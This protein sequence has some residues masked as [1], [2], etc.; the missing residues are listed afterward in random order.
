MG[1]VKASSA[2]QSLKMSF[3]SIKLALLVGICG[4]VPFKKDGSEIVLGDV[5]IS[6]TIVELDYGRQYHG[7]FERKDSL[8]DVHGRPNEEILGLLQRWK[9]PAILETLRHGS[10]GHLRYLLQRLNIDYP[11]ASQDMLFQSDYIH[12]HRGHCIG[13]SDSPGTV[14]KSALT[15]SCS[16]TLCDERQLVARYRLEAAKSSSKIPD[17]SIHIGSIGTGNAVIKSAR[18]RDQHTQSEGIIAFEMEGVGVWDKFNCLVIKGVCDYAD[19]HKSKVWQD[20]AAAAAAAV[21]KEVLKQYVMPQKLP[22][23]TIPNDSV[24]ELFSPSRQDSFRD[25]HSFHMLTPRYSF[26]SAIND[27]EEHSV[28]DPYNR[29]AQ[30]R[31]LASLQFPQ[32]QGR[33][34]KIEAA[35]EQTY[36]WVLRSQDK[37]V[38]TWDDLVT[39]LSSST[40]TRWIYWISGKP[41]SGKSTLMKFLGERLDVQEH[42]L[43]WAQGCSVIRASYFSWSPGNVLQKS[44]EGLLRSL[45]LQIL[46]QK[47]GLMSE[48]I[49]DMRW[50]A[51]QM[52]STTLAD[53]NNLEL[54]SS[55]QRCIFS[56]QNVFIRV[57]FFV[58]GLDEF[59]G[60]DEIRQE[61][62]AIFKRL[63]CTGNVKIFL[64][65]RPWNIFQDSFSDIPKIRLEDLTRDDIDLYV[66]ANFLNNPRFQYLLRCDQKAAEALIF[67][68]T[69]KAEGVF[70]WVRLVVRDLLKAMRDGDGIRTLYRKLEEIPADL[71]DYFKHLFSS[72][73]PQHMREASIILQTA[74]HEEHDFV[75]LHPLRLLD[76][77]FTDESSPDFALA[78]S[79]KH[80]KIS[81]NDREAL[82]FRLDSTIR[83]LNSRCMGLLECTYNPDSFFDLFDEESTEEFQDTSLYQG[84]KFEPSIYSHV[85][86]SPTLLRPFML[87]VDF[88][89]RCCRDFLLFPHIQSLLHQYTGGR[90]DARM[91]IINARISQFLALQNIECGRSISLGIASYLVSALSVPEWKEAAV[92]IRAARILQ[93]AI[94]AFSCYDVASSPGWYIDFVLASWQEEKSNFLTLAIDF[95]MRAYCMAYLTEDQVQ[96]KKGRPILD[97][98][99]RPRF[100]TEQFLNIGSQV[101]NIDLLHRVLTFGADPNGLYQGVSVWALFLS[102]V[103]E[104]LQRGFHTSAT[105]KEAYLMA[106][107][108]MI[109]RGAAL[110]LP[111][112]W[113]L[114]EGRCRL[115]RYGLFE[116]GY[117]KK[118]RWPKDIPTIEQ[119]VTGLSQPS[120][121]VTDLLATFQVHFGPE[122]NG[123]IELAKADGYQHLLS[124]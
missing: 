97:Y 5:I 109:N 96:A 94:E 60:T 50:S 20:Y 72:I 65:S 119:A 37:N 90:Y 30:Q 76:L 75:A 4:A 67:A 25:V 19:S 38:H 80:D 45:L 3:S 41:G 34:Q 40:E 68:V 8:L 86:D 103:A 51:A 24:R 16:D 69:D 98:I 112:S 81:I 23:Q 63:A 115:H 116:I 32:M 88:F 43:P 56:L 64:S 104:W 62:I 9:I 95:D 12:K 48:V 101:P 2:S 49:D 123:L 89:H 93:P 108:M 55:L 21:A 42:M 1:S 71:N 39:W 122:L 26:D 82:R 13:C 70:L 85:F 92:S 91:L 33:A 78:D 100:A 57:L 6:E 27:L 52:P 107:R 18:H 102:S 124:K 120:Y 118:D 110:V 114:S 47:P 31:I 105:I 10:M 28:K 58:D 29:H 61:L 111:C 113:V 77:S 83:R 7:S 87:T 74:L 84:R 14:C 99:L 15:A 36:E 46:K 117:K 44:L 59:E 73:D 35:H 53:W 22:Q 121:A 54:F 66:R 79:F 17:L 106:L 11:G